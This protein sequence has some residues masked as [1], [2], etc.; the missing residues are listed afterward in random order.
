MNF[1]NRLFGGSALARAAR[2]VLL[3]DEPSTAADAAEPKPG[4]DAGDGGDADDAQDG[5]AD[6]TGGDEGQDDAGAGDAADDAADPPAPVALDEAAIR[7]EER[8][9]VATVFAS[10][11]AKGRE[12]I[13]ANLLANPKLEAAEI[14]G[15]LP[16]LAASSSDA[17]L[18]QL[19]AGTNPDLGA[20]AEGKSGSGTDA[21]SSWSQTFDTL[22]WNNND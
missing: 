1:R 10:E 8:Q 2:D 15:M 4:D 7:A 20:G 5:A 3:E 21:K 22:G 11:E 18:A 12:R 16:S 9:R 13:A 6:G 19:A 17:M 14:V